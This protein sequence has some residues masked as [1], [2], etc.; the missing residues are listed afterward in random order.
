MHAQCPCSRPAASQRLLAE[1]LQTLQGPKHTA[2]IR[3][4]AL[5]LQVRWVEGGHIT[6]FVLCQPVFRKAIT[7]A[8]SRLKL[9]SESS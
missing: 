9:D 7:D 2:C 8:L 4:G 3:F 5:P 1:G 6:A